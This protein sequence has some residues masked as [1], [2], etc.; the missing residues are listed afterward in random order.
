MDILTTE[1]RSERMRRVR[2]KGTKPELVV[3]QS[4]HAMGFR[5][6]LHRRDLPGRPDIVL[7]SRRVAIFVHGCFW[8]RHPGCV[9]TTTPKTNAQYWLPKFAE[10][11][12]RDARVNA[13][14][15]ASGWRVRLVWECETAQPERLANSLREFLIC[16]GSDA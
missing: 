4:L 13:A 3:R 7:P 10:N 12:A 11:E 16:S 1:Q 2:Q 8:H 5:Y 14:L 15:G 6:R 9:R